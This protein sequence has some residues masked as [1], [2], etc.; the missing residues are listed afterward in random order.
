MISS[1]SILFEFDIN[2]KIST[3]LF[4]LLVKIDNLDGS[5]LIDPYCTCYDPSNLIVKCEN[6]KAMI[7]K[8]LTCAF[9]VYFN[10]ASL[11]VFSDL[12]G[13]S[14]TFSNI[15]HFVMGLEF[16][17][18]ISTRM[19]HENYVLWNVFNALN[20]SK[21]RGSFCKRVIVLTNL[22]PSTNKCLI[23][24]QL[25]QNLKDGRSVKIHILLIEFKMIKHSNLF[26][27]FHLYWWYSVLSEEW[28]YLTDRLNYRGSAFFDSDSNLRFERGG[29]CETTCE[30]TSE[31]IY[32]D[33]N[34]YCKVNLSILVC[35]YCIHCN[36]G[37]F[38]TIALVTQFI[39]FT[40]FSVAQ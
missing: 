3:N 13:W 28:F 10:D 20:E 25:M 27:R 2:D 32:N 1:F 34:V 15:P 39:M 24:K 33:N 14:G 40:L 17:G 5:T 26:A 21:V 36:W 29:I 30:I 35:I 9:C 4:N 12:H 18:F 31:R 23:D 11:S 19:Q 16:V 6:P 8:D 22:S 38:Q 7:L 37:A